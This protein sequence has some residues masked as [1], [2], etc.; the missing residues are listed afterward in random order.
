MVDRR[1]GTP[2]CIL[3]HAC[4]VAQ[5]GRLLAVM[6]PSGSGK[7]TLIDVLAGNTGRV[8]A[9]AAAG[10]S[11]TPKHIWARVFPKVQ[12]ASQGLPAAAA[13][14]VAADW[15]AGARLAVR[16]ARGVAVVGRVLV[17]GA[18]RRLREFRDMSCYVQQEDVLV[19]S[20]SV[21]EALTTAALLKLP[22]S[23]TRHGV[24]ER[25]EAVIQELV[26][27]VAW[28]RCRYGWLGRRAFVCTGEACAGTT[29]T[30][31]DLRPWQLPVQVL[32][33]VTACAHARASTAP[34]A[35]SAT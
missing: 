18:P 1:T 3:A 31:A 11:W 23:V 4:G 13:A 32:V 27:V 9:S 33:Q 5:P 16:S 35:S 6:G 28:R 10:P 34:S 2:R 20:A 17:D 26:G 14:A 8:H 7:S 12:A 29:K 30:M 19:F 21:R 15:A 25:V 24:A 22:Y